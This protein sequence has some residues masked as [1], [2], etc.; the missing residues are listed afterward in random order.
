RTKYFSS[1]CRLPHVQQRIGAVDDDVLARGAEALRHGPLRKPGGNRE[2][3][4]RA[5]RMIADRAAQPDGPLH[6]AILRRS[7]RLCGE[8][9][10]RCRPT[11][12]GASLLDASGSKRI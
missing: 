6:R 9:E 8:P 11:R 10:P 1:L 3:N 2:I 4:L 7:W 5:R 12:S